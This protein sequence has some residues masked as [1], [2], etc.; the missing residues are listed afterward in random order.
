[1]VHPLP[2][3]DQPQGFYNT[4]AAQ[5]YRPLAATTP[6]QQLLVRFTGD[7]RPVAQSI[8]GVIR[9]LDPELVP[10]TYTLTE[11][12]ER[13]TTPARLIAQIALAVGFS[14]LLLSVAG[15]YGLAA[16]SVS[17]RTR[18]RV[19]ARASPSTNCMTR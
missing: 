13:Q 5:L 19:C 9:D 8:A 15:L 11:F 10:T 6:G 4:T 16:Y 7:S 18:D 14:T 1:M 2:E 12:F 3:P 17:R